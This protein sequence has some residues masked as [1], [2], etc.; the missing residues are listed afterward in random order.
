[1]YLNLAEKIPASRDIFPV[2]LLLAMKFT[3]FIIAFACMQT[4]ANGY[5]QQINLSEKN[6]SLNKIFSAIEKQ[7]SYDFFY[8]ANTIRNIKV[9]A[10]IKNASIND[11]LIQIFKNLPLTYTL[12]DKTI[13]VRLK[14][15]S[16]VNIEPKPVQEIVSLTVKGK[17]TDA[18]GLALPGVTIKLNGRSL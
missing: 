5:A 15:H 14:P 16:S 13:I 4:M 12:V 9:S 3:V 6:V 1:M 8:K 10:D 18:K 7:S 2:K 17:V 11:A